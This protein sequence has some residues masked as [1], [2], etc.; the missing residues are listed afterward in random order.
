MLDDA[1][2]PHLTASPSPDECEDPPGVT[3]PDSHGYHTGGLQ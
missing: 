3:S 2:Q 1:L